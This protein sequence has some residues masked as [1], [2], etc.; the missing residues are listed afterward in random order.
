MS[1]IFRARSILHLYER[2]AGWTKRK[3]ELAKLYLTSLKF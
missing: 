2:V 3:V 1:G